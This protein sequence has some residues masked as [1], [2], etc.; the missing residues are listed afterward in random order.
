MSEKDNEMNKLN[1]YFIKENITHTMLTTQVGR[2]FV[3]SIN[4]TTLKVLILGGERL[5]ELQDSFSYQVIDAYGPTETFAYI[6]SIKIEDKLDS[7]SVGHI[8]YNTKCYILD[9]ELRRMP[10]GAVGELY[11]SG[12]QIS[13]GYLNLEDENEKAFIGKG[14]FLGMLFI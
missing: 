9:N 4:D 10:V 6:A 14:V 11:I 5:G 7:S 12:Y 3:Q 1:E 13:E 8:N 2:L